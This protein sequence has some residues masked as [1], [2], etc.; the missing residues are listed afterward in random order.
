MICPECGSEYREGFTHC[1]DCDV[2]LV[3]PEPLAPE[4][5]L[6]SVFQSGNPAIIPIVESVLR[7]SEIEFMTSGN[8]MQALQGAI[9]SPYVVPVEFW[10]RS[11]DEAAAREILDGIENAPVVDE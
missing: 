7:D 9:G 3:E 2:D 5:E 11:N 10:V 1:N 6:V 8:A 4:V